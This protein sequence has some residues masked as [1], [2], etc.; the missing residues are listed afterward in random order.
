VLHG[1]GTSRDGRHTPQGVQA[2]SPSSLSG[3]LGHGEGAVGW[4]PLE[5]EVLARN[6]G[7]LGPDLGPRLDGRHAAQHAAL[8]VLGA[9]Q[10]PGVGGQVV[11]KVAAVAVQSNVGCGRLLVGLMWAG[12]RWRGVVS[13]SKKCADGCVHAS[14]ACR[15]RQ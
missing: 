15:A 10:R 13:H 8:V 4:P 12:A 14:H 2:F 3:G 1:T 9:L 6:V 11:G 5:V 7:G